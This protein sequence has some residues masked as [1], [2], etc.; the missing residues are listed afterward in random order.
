MR[1][2]FI[3]HFTNSILIVSLAAFFLASCSSDEKDP[4]VVFTSLDA[5]KT[6]TFIEETITLNLAGTGYTDVSAT[7]SN[8]TIKITKLASTIFEISSTKATSA[9][10]YIEL[11]NNTYHE[12]KNITLN[13][14]EHGV[15]D[16]NTVE[17]IKVNVDKT[18]KAI[19]LFGEPINKTTST[20]GLLEFWSYP[21][22]G[23]LLGIKKSTSIID[24]INVYSSNYYIL[25]ENNTKVYYTNYPY[26][27]GYGWKINSTIMD[28]VITKLG[29]PTNKY[30]STTDP[31]ATLRTY[32]FTN[33][34]MYL[35]F[36]GA[37]ED[38]Y[39]GKTIKSLFLY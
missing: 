23:I 3:K 10:I 39:I 31:T 2:S 26:D 36:Y 5:N 38:D 1:K 13:F 27:I 29:V 20:D 37:T 19:S 18:T 35:G 30:S 24:N 17:G 4:I 16:F 21:A 32:R 12:T 28:A 14:Y 6:D 7:S 8:T 11:K 34:N 15:L 22:K 9:A 25:L 33:Q